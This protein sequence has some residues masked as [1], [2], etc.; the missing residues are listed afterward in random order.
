MS[1][2]HFVLQVRDLVFR[3]N[4]SLDEV[5]KLSLSQACELVRG[6]IVDEEDTV[7]VDDISVPVTQSMIDEYEEMDTSQTDL[8]VVAAS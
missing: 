1:E 5:E 2:S 4:H 3:L 7:H 8:G 6:L